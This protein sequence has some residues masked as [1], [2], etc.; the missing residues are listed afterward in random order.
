MD[1]FT[2]RKGCTMVDLLIRKTAP[3]DVAAV[4]GVLQEGKAAIAELGISQ[5][6]TGDY[7]NRSDV[8]RDIADGSS[9]LAEDETGAVLGTISLSFGGDVTYDRI[10][11]SWLTQSTSD[12]PRYGA[13]HRVAVA[14]AAARRGVMT[15]LVNEAERIARDA[16]AESVRAD[17]HPGN[18]PMRRMLARLGFTECGVIML[19]KDDPEPERIAYEKLV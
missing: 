16:G 19:Q 9:Y 15:A 11:G 14:R 7:P 13:V 18:I 17:T 3:A 8:E 10:D 12:S 1:S 5:W 4:V 6:Q 2:D